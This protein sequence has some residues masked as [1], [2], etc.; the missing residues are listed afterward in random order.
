M[1][2][3]DRW[4]S[5]EEINPDFAYEEREE[6][7]ELPDETEEEAPGEKRRGGIRLLTSIQIF[8]SAAVLIAALVLRTLGGDTYRKVR[9]W[10]FSAVNDSLVAEEQ[11]EQ[12]RR[13]V[14]G[15][16]NGLS[17]GGLQGAEDG[18]KTSAAPETSSVPASVSSG[19]Q[20]GAVSSAESGGTPQSG[21]PSAQG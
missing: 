2:D 3:R 21:V 9:E 15:L 1:Q 12:V 7:A 10:Y 20:G 19:V 17:A 18:R 5:D 4:N 13:T 11:T 16:W 6:S 8:G 14:V